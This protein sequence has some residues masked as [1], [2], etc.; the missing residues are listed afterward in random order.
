MLWSSGV[1]DTEVARKLENSGNATH[2]AIS[3]AAEGTD[4]ELE[5]VDIFARLS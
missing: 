5:G 1:N 4:D 3:Q 2:C